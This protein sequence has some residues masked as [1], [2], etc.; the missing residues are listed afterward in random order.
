MTGAHRTQQDRQQWEDFPH[1]VDQARLDAELTRRELD[2]T[3]TA[4]WRKVDAET[5]V[6]L[7]VRAP[8]LA[9]GLV[10]VVVVA[11]LLMHR[12]HDS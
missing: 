10:L 3:L 11:R 7:R 6:W 2:E 4:L 8:L 12:K 5:R 1:D 9:G